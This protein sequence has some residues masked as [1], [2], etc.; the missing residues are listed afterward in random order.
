MTEVELGSKLAQHNPID[1]LEPLQKRQVP[2]FHI[3]GSV[4]TVVPLEK[5][6]GELAARYRKL[7]GDMTL[8]VIEGKGH[9]MWPGWFECKELV[10]FV[11]ANARK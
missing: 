7:G 4:D 2:I 8:Q 5:N 11:I 3:H 10:E 6:S 9:D 1:R